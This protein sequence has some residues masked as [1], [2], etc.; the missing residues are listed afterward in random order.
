MN[1]LTVLDFEDGKVYQYQ[2]L[3]DEQ[4]VDA[5]IFMIHQGHRLKS[6]EYMTHADPDI[7]IIK[8]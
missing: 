7:V 1:T 6:C 4:I 5:E 3:S 2:N 8:M